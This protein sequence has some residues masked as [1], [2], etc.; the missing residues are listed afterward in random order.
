MA[1]EEQL[2]ILHQGVEAWNKWR[3]KN[4]FKDVDLSGA[5]LYYAPLS[6]VN[7]HSANLRR[8]NIINA[9][10][11]W[12]NLAGANLCEAYLCGAYLRG[13]NLIR[14]NFSGAYL[15]EA[16]LRETFL[17]RAVFNNADLSGAYLNNA[18]LVDV[19]FEG[20]TLTNCYIHGI[21][22]WRLNL[23][24]AIQKDLII[25]DFDESKVTVDNLEVAQFIYL[26]LNNEKVRY[27]IDTITSKVV[28]ILG[29]FT[30]ERKTILDAIK[31][32]VRK[33]NYSPILFDFEGPRN[34]DICETVSI[35]AHMARFVI[36]DITDARSI[37][38]ELESIVPQLP[39]VPIQ[40]LILNSDYEYGLFEHIRKF[41][42]V[43]EPCRY[44]NQ[45]D[46]L[47]SFQEKVIAT[48]EAKVIE[49]SNRSR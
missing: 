13:A 5:N 18:N 33:Q 40:P 46:L 30:P 44:K 10:L 32:E 16:D 4:P 23:R 24:N 7:L 28:L 29:R 8:A 14:A 22:A 35:L 12:S 47:A 39:S 2:T 43:L 19:N 48:A 42:W 17:E 25:T 41:P 34:R 37:S 31:E 38:A 6:G 36:A 21:S 26:L 45:K 9:E 20:S 27:V 1:N 3:E 15:N 49:L 11:G